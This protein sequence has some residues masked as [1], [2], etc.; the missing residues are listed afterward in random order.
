[1]RSLVLIM[2]IN[3]ILR[4]VYLFVIINEWFIVLVDERKSFSILIIIIIS[5]QFQIFE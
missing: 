3:D 2:H 4:N 5:I 1:M